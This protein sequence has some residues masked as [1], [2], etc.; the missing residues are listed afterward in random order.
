M[1]VRYRAWA[2]SPARISLVTLCGLM[3]STA[4]VA[5][6]DPPTV[7][8]RNAG[9]ARMLVLDASGS[10]WI[11]LKEKD[12]RTPRRAELAAQFVDAFTAELAKETPQRKLGMVR[13]GYQH[14]WLDKTMPPDT[15]V[16][17]L[18]S[19]VEVVVRPHSDAAQVRNDLAHEAGVGRVVK[20]TDYHPK[21][22][23][24]LALAI[25]R[26]A[27]AAP[28][29][30]AKLVVVTD[31]DDNDRDCPDPCGYGRRLDERLKRLL[32]RRKIRVRY[33]IAAGLV[34]GIGK[35]AEQI[36]RCFGADFEVLE[37]LDQARRIGIAVGK[38]L[39]AEE[40]AARGAIMVALQDAGGQPVDL[41]A[42]GS[43]EVRRKNAPTGLLSSPG[44]A[45][46]KPGTYGTSLQL[47]DRRWDLDAVV[48]AGRTTDVTFIIAP[49]ILQASLVDSDKRP[50]EN[51]LDVVWEIEAAPGQPARSARRVKGARLN[52][53]LPAGKYLIKVH[54][55]TR[56]GETT[57]T[58]EA[59]K[60]YD[61][62]IQVDPY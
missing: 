59:G 49:A 5:Q 24:P 27:M 31:L 4:A 44:G 36:A 50:I 29:G 14:S 23:T 40:R 22:F 6:T 35:R 45:T 57:M 53:A 8:A 48:A 41:P 15:R 19:D 55:S 17:T 25:E 52:Q 20:T 54:T 3:L 7:T 9:P 26:A 13:L 34:G 18:C 60:E 28:A 43:V 10:M 56:K 2:L 46:V 1:C 30:G 61:E 32:A 16:E 51:A 58:L 12:K 62:E 33:V 11:R 38:R 39:I 21:G 42:G 37:N 47:G